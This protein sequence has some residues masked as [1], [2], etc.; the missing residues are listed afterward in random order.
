MND[1]AGGDA[2]DVDDTDSTDAL[3]SRL[4]LIEDQP[5]QERAAAFVLVYD[6]LRRALEGADAP[7]SRD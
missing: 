6:E 2:A 1:A 7:A 3:L 4:R 5:L